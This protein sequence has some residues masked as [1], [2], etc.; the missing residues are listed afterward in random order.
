MLPPPLPATC[1]LASALY[2][3]SENPGTPDCWKSVLLRCSVLLA[4]QTGSALLQHPT[5]QMQSLT[6][7]QGWAMGPLQMRGWSP[8]LV[9]F[10]LSGWEGAVDW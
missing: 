5:N 6:G 10:C 9:V 8:L 4:E 3:P 7:D 1:S 2:Q